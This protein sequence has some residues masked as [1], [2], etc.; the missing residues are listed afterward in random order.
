MDNQ[1]AALTWLVRVS[2]AYRFLRAYDA[3]PVIMRHTGESRE[4]AVGHLRTIAHHANR[5]APSTWPA[6]VKPS[7]RTAGYA[8]RLTEILGSEF[9]NALVDR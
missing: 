7:T 6:D 5:V 3:D 9:V 2:F 1:T 4:W 8:R